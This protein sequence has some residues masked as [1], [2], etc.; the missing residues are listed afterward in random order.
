[1]SDIAAEKRGGV[2]ALAGFALFGRTTGRAVAAL[3]LAQLSCTIISAFPIKGVTEPISGPV[4][5]KPT[6]SLFYAFMGIA[7]LVALI[8]AAAWLM[9]AVLLLKPAL[10]W[11]PER[12]NR[13]VGNFALVTL[14][15]SVSLWNEKG[16]KAITEIISFIQS[17]WP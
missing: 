11:F 17:H 2:S 4:N 12:V 10:N 5:W 13:L 16:S 6:H 9:L 7:D 8:C 15:L 14:S 3:A 1:M